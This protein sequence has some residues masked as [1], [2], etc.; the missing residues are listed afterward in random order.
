MLFII[1][2]KDFNTN[3]F[4]FLETSKNN[5]SIEKNANYP[6]VRFIYST[7]NYS[8]NNLC[9]HIPLKIYKFEKFY[10]KY[11]CNFH[12]IDNEECIQFISLLEKSILDHPFNQNYYKEKN[13]LYRLTEQIHNG[14]IKAYHNE[15]HFSQNGNQL[16][17]KISGIWSSHDVYG[18][19]YKYMYLKNI[20]H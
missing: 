15:N 3:D 6:F 1:S 20:I 5:E 10:D 12:P 7:Q 17:L 14:E 19:T 13:P 4:Y 8:V 9:I 16:I 18:I 2:M 11:R